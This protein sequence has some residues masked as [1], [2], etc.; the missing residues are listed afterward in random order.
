MPSEQLKYCPRCKT[1][2]PFSAFSK[3]KSRRDGLHGYCK[4]CRSNIYKENPEPTK[5]RAHRWYQENRE[6]AT[7]KSEEWERSNPEKR[8]EIVGR[9]RKKYPEKAKE[10]QRKAYKVMSLNPKF[11]L[12]N[13]M[14]SRI[15]DSIKQNKN[16]N[17]W[18]GLVGYTLNM[19]MNHLESLW[20]HRMSW[21]NYGEWHIDHIIPVSVF[22][23]SEPEHIDFKRCWA[24][25]NLQPMWAKENMSKWAKISEDFQLCLALRED[26]KCH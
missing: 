25:T 6:H 1:K 3:C 9:Y 15:Y 4:E 7:K 17:H 23:F 11:R 5:I 16:G 19:L 2:K 22:N 18:E 8:R 12:N 24:L 14:R 13:S 20:E 21:D 10:R 26:N